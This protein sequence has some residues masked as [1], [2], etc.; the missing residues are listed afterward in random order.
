[1]VHRGIFLYINKPTVQSLSIDKTN[2]RVC[3]RER[4]RENERDSQTDR[5]TETGRQTDLV[6]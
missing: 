3:V 4:E 6:L 2:S 5:Q 1:M